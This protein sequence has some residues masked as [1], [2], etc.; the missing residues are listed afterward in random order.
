MEFFG[1]KIKK[2]IF[3]GGFPLTKPISSSCGHKILE[4]LSGIP[5]GCI[6][7]NI[8]KGQTKTLILADYSLV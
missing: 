7:S 1:W 8:L 4:T 6:E 3:R 2:V 5:C